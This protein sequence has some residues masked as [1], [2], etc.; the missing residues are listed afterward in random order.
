M[1][2]S[3]INRSNNINLNQN[4]KKAPYKQNFGLFVLAD[5]ETA[6]TLVGKIINHGNLNYVRK[7]V[8]LITLSKKRK[9]I[10]YISGEDPARVYNEAGVQICQTKDLN[11]FGTLYAALENV[12]GKYLTTKVEPQN[13][14]QE[15]ISEIANR[16]INTLKDCPK[17][18]N[19][20]DLF[21]KPPM[22]ITDSSSGAISPFAA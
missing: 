1:Y 16:L 15:T 6:E 20:S 14:K 8:D 2:I 11:W 21:A 12:A 5:A 13:L 10:I 4:T 22:P 17:V 7:L 18:K 9:E 19:I 3:P